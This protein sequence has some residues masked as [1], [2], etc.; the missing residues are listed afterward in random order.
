MATTNKGFMPLKNSERA[1][2]AGAA[3]IGLADAKESLSVSVRLRRRQDAPAIDTRGLVTAASSRRKSISREDYSATYGA[4]QSDLAQIATFARNHGLKVVESSAARRTVVLAG[5]AE[6]LGSAFGVELHRYQS[7]SQTYRGY[8]GQLHVPEILADVIESVHGLDNRQVAR[9]MYRAAASGQATS[10][11]TPP[12][13]ANLYQVPPTGAAGQTIAILE[14]GGGYK[15]ADIQSY[16]NNTVHMPAPSVTAVGVDGATNSPGQSADIEV[17]LDIDVAGSVAPGAKIVVYFAPNTLQGWIDAITTAIHDTVNRPSVISI[18]WAGE[19]SGW[20]S[21]IQSVSAALE[22]AAIVGV[23]V[24]VSSG[25]GG[26]GSPAEVLYPPS[27]PWVTGCG[28]VTIEDVSGSNFVEST[29]AGS[30]GGVSNVFPLPAWQT[31]VNVTPSVNPRGHIGRGVPDISGNADPASGYMLILNGAPTGPWGGTSAVAPFYAGMVAVLNTELDD[32]IGYLNPSLY[33]FN[34]SSAFVDVTTGNNGG[35]SAS[36]GWDACTGLGSVVGA[37]IANSLDGIGLRGIVA[38][39]ANSDGRLEAFA[40]GTD[41]ALWHMWQTEPNGGWS[42]WS[43]LGGVLT[44]DRAVGRNADGRLE[45]FVRGTDDAL[46]HIWQVSPNGGWSSWASLGGV[47][48]SDPFVSRNLDGRLEVFARGT[49]HAL[50]HVW[51]MAPNSGWSAWASLGGVITSDPVV[52]QNNDGRLEAFTRGTDNALYHIWQVTANGGWSGWASLGGVITTIPS[53]AS[54]ADGRLEA[55]AR[56]SDK[57]LW[58]IWQM[59]PGGVWSG[60][61]SFGGVITSDP[62]V[63]RNADGRLEAFARGEDNALWH[64]WQVQPNKSWSAWASLGGIITSDP[65][66][67]NDA[68]GRLEA[69]ARGTDDALWHI[70]QIA[71]NGGWSGWSSLGGAIIAESER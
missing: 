7:R 55:F 52:G 25:D 46:W 51:Q 71:P 38:V 4:A 12:Q 26:A 69:F 58:H 65:A 30:G 35:Y 14:F 29:W 70:W 2:A 3:R 44:S 20:G 24:F 18:S 37:S 50:W 64:I 21:S 11:L 61:S 59:S 62:S 10:P 32:S 13:V 36:V 56:G 43:S 9:P 41:N 28:G 53:V 47:I 40:A 54:N 34:G 67:T 22:E 17:V 39:N 45:V 23:S 8:E 27:D 1:P 63:G 19:E 33:A 57:A 68:D 66:L 49:D 6:Q 42:T 16:F 60:W 5:S 48:T 15:I 31:W